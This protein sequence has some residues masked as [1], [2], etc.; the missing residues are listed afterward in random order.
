MKC[1]I[2]V[3]L[4][5][6][7][8][9]ATPAVPLDTPE[10]AAAKAAHFAEYNKAAA[11]AGAP[12]Y[13][14]PYA[15]YPYSYGYPYSY[16]AYP[17]STYAAP[18]VT[19]QGYLADTP[20]V[21]AA[22]AVHFA[23]HAKAASATGAYPYYGY[24]YAYSGY[25]YAYSG[26]PY[27]APVVTPSGYLADTPEVAAAKA[28]HFA[29]VAKAKALI[30]LTLAVAVQAQ[31]FI[32][33]DTPAVATAKA[34][35]YAEYAKAAARVGAPLPE[36]YRT[37]VYIPPSFAPAPVVTPE[38]FI[39][40]TPEVAAAKAAHLAEVARATAAAPAAAPAAYPYAE[41][42]RAYYNYYYP[43]LTRSIYSGHQA[44]PTVLPSGY[45]ADTP[46]VA[47]AKIT[48]LYKLYQESARL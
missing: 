10:V 42:Y 40:D 2:A 41:Y 24:P 17:Y 13:A 48:H 45:L 37:V 25:P 3:A 32:P 9:A 43:S 20:E 30:V 14:Y 8:V 19:P 23:E 12:G 44:V 46:E 22:K 15:A 36:V 1:F 27:A 38:G 6:A 18:V 5:V 33:Q 28:A 16:A 21:A 26:Y 35:H 47:H 39:T 31:S 4:L 29:E 34:A 7:A 11:A